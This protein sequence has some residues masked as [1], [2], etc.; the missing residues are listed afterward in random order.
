MMNQLLNH[1]KMKE[2]FGEYYTTILGIDGKENLAPELVKKIVETTEKN[3]K[4]LNI[5]LPLSYNDADCY[6]TIV[7]EGFSKCLLSVCHDIDSRL[8]VFLNKCIYKHQT[9][10]STI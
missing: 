4:K 1:A 8:F 3:C 10:H 9:C 7:C 2:V 5:P 6:S